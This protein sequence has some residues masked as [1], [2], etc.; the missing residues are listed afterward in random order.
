MLNFEMTGVPMVGKDY[1]LY[2]TGFD[3]S[4]LAE[5]SNAHAGENLIGLLPTAQELGLFRRSDNYPF[6][7]VFGVPSHTYCT[8]DF[9]NFDHYHGVDDEPQIMNFA[10]MADVVNRIIPVIEGISNAAEQEVTGN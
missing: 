2:I 4:N 8:F 3:K 9:T 10:H 5:I 1:F 6:F 7:E